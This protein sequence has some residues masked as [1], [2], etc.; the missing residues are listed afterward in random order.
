MFYF[1]V[2][3]FVLVLDAVCVDYC[4]GC[5]FVGVV[6]I[7]VVG[8]VVVVCLLFYNIRIINVFVFFTF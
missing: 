3:F 7:V 1:I 4:L 6:L 8:A 5:C 2:L